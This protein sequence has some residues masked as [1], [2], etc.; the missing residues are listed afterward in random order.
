MESVFDPHQI[1][2][3]FYED[4]FSQPARYLEEI[5]RFIG[6]GSEEVDTSVIERVVLAASKS[7]APNALRDFLTRQYA[8]MLIALRSRLGYLPK[9]WGLWRNA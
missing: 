6:L 8:P 5:C 9:S 2:Y 1:L 7:E 4:V 3:L